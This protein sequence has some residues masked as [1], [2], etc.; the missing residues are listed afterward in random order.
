MFAAVTI[1]WSDDERAQLEASTRRPTSAQALAQ[2]S[3][4][5]M[6]AADGLTNTEIAQ[7]LGM[8]RPNGDQVAHAVAEHRLDGLSDER[9]PGR[10]RTISDLTSRSSR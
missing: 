8:G 7:R 1:E 2:R 4:I 10:P 9:R 3:R 5:V 6:L